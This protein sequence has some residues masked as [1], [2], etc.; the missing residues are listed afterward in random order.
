[1]ASTLKAV[2]E[3]GAEHRRAL[4]E[5]N[6]GA[7]CRE[8]KRIAAK[9]GGGIDNMRVSGLSESTGFGNRFVLMAE[10]AATMGLAPLNEID[11]NRAAR[12]GGLAELQCRWT[13]LEVELVVRRAINNIHTQALG[14]CERGL[15]RR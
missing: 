15:T 6:L 5:R 4:N 11:L 8:D 1:M 12:S 14:E 10:L 9:A 2:I 3:H 13:G 7:E